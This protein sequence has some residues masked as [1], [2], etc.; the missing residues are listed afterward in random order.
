MVVLARPNQMISQA[1]YG[2]GPNVPH[3]CCKWTKP[4][5]K[6]ENNANVKSYIFITIK[7]IS[8]ESILVLEWLIKATP[9]QQI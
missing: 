9:W 1:L 5:D 2:T 3:P 6:R 7:T 8:G 4:F